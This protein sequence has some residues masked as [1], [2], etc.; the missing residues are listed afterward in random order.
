LE[1][2]RKLTRKRV[3]IVLEM[4]DQYTDQVYGRIMDVNIEGFMLLAKQQMIP[5]QQYDMVLNL[6]QPIKFQQSIRMVAECRWCQP[7]NTSGYFGAGFMVISV[8]VT[9]REA[10]KQLVDEF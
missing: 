1:E 9:M 6:P 10:W 3:G 7:S 5:N 4:Q 2:H 8:E